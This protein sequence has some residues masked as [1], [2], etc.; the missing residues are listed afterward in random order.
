MSYAGGFGWADET[1]GIEA[2][3]NTA[4]RVGSISKTFV[5]IAALKLAE[6]GLIDM[7]QDA[8]SYLEPD[9]PP[10]ERRISM[11][12]LLTHS[13]GLEDMVTGVAVPNVSDTLP[14]SVSVRRY[15]PAQTIGQGTISYSNYG[16]ALAA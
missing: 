16:I 2:A 9:F 7:D 10:F 3:E 8:A 1:M 5:A 6:Q 13:A 11:R 14:L 12:M 15:R 4:F